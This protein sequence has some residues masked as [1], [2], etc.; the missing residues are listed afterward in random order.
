MDFVM[1]ANT[2]MICNFSHVNNFHML[3][4]IVGISSWSRVGVERVDKLNFPDKAS[5]QNNHRWHA[6]LR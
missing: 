5:N 3:L 6:G 1:I 4:D 2:E